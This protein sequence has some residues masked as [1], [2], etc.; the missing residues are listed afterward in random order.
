[1]MSQQG[2]VALGP[3]PPSFQSETLRWWLDPGLRAFL[4]V[5]AVPIVH[6]SLGPIKKFQFLLNSEGKKMN[7]KLKGM[8]FFKKRFYYF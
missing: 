8:S 4:A 6:N 1:M 2:G 5:G 7:F 3:S